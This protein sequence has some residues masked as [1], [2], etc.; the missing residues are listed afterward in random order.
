M[1]KIYVTNLRKYNEG[2]I[3]GEWVSLP[4]EGLEEILDKISNN[5]KDELLISDYETDISNL[6]I[7]EYD[8]ILQLNEIAEEIDNLSDDEVIALQ[9]YLEQYNDIEQALE[10]VRQGNYTIYYDCD[11]MSDVAYQVVNESGLLDGV[12]ETIKG[13]FDYEA[14]GRD[15]DIEGTFIQVDN[16]IIELY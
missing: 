7:S 13:Y 10:E 14:Y 16:N 9:A 8:D 4:H 2:Q 11:D 3:I 5:G 1:L 12:P 15:I 6:K